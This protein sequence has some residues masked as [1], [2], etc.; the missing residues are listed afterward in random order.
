MGVKNLTSSITHY[1]DVLEKVVPKDAVIVVDGDAMTYQAIEG[2]SP[3]ADLSR[4]RSLIQREFEFLK[5]EY[6][7]IVVFFDGSSG[8][9]KIITSIE[10]RQRVTRETMRPDRKRKLLLSIPLMKATFKRVLLELGIEI[11]QCWGE[12]DRDMAEYALS[13]NAY[14]RTGDSDAFCFGINVI[15]A[16]QFSHE[17]DGPLKYYP[18]DALTQ[19]FDLKPRHLA[20]LAL[21]VNNDYFTQKDTA[22]ILH[23]LWRG[24]PM[25]MAEKMNEAAIDTCKR[26]NEENSVYE[27]DNCQRRLVWYSLGRYL[28]HR[29]QETGVLLS[30]ESPREIEQS[31]D[32]LI[33]GGDDVS[34]SSKRKLIDG[35]A[36]YNPK[37][38]ESAGE[39]T[40]FPDSFVKAYRNGLLDCDLAD[41]FLRSSHEWW[42]D[43]VAEEEFAPVVS[44]P[45]FKHVRRLLYGLVHDESVVVNEYYRQAGT[46]GKESTWDYK[47]H[48]AHPLKLT[49]MGS[50]F[51]SL[52][53]FWGPEHDES[54]RSCRSQIGGAERLRLACAILLDNDPSAEPAASVCLLEEEPGDR[55]VDHWIT[56]VS[57]FSQWSLREASTMPKATVRHCAKVALLVSCLV[58]Q[59]NLS[60]FELHSIASGI[61]AH[62]NAD[63]TSSGCF[64]HSKLTNSNLQAANFGEAAL[65]K[66][67]QVIASAL[68]SLI[69]MSYVFDALNV[70]KT[71]IDSYADLAFDYTA[72]VTACEAVLVHFQKGNPVVDTLATYLEVSRRFREHSDND[73]SLL[74]VR[75]MVLDW[76]GIDYFELEGIGVGRSD[77]LSEPSSTISP[78]HIF[79]VNCVGE[80]THQL[81]C[82]AEMSRE[83]APAAMKQAMQRFSEVT[84]KAEDV[85]TECGVMLHVG[86]R[87]VQAQ[88]DIDSRKVHSVL[89]IEGTVYDDVEQLHDIPPDMSENLSV[90]V[91][92]LLAE[93]FRDLPSRRTGYL[94]AVVKMTDDRTAEWCRVTFDFSPTGTILNCR[95]T[96]L[97]IGLFCIQTDTSITDVYATS[98]PSIDPALMAN[99]TAT[100]RFECEHIARRDD[101]VFEFKS[102]TAVLSCCTHYDPPQGRI[103]LV[104]LPGSVR[105]RRS[106]GSRLFA[107]FR[108]SIRDTS[109]AQ[110]PGLAEYLKAVRSYAHMCSAATAVS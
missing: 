71:T 91:S 84:G 11:Q 2:R 32:I 42:S 53:D 87:N 101:E 33:A 81:A 60:N 50:G 88:K 55:A 90:E 110:L 70:P 13:H 19:L 64:A 61:I 109:S 16:T 4:S 72:V 43:P 27:H 36:A 52:R 17:D 28:E 108:Y 76:T 92:K 63:A 15:H 95:L 83:Y 96:N 49:K 1:C 98:S 3:W 40:Q 10:R 37:G 93:R 77:V 20:F 41:M 23:R 85:G 21:A 86:L 104:D 25:F 68:S 12:A 80:E 7:R 29:E 82:F 34:P 62:F 56:K 57:E 44:L 5:N 66:A 8:E 102:F 106:T 65:R 14:V 97:R 107:D 9:N 54:G 22:W 74:L 35:L 6:Q 48:F 45:Q 105:G 39:T 59:L 31:L 38:G 89:Q 79:D 67:P 51:W 46:D 26:R 78:D 18:G 94:E 24:C 30:V 100:T 75:V 99:L 103:S 69:H 58:K 73:F 47:P